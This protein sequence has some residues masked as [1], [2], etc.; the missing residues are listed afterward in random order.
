VVVAAVLSSLGGGEPNRSARSDRRQD[1]E[2]GA[3]ETPMDRGTSEARRIALV[4]PQRGASPG[5]CGPI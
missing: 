5:R 4:H 1:I 2:V 3:R